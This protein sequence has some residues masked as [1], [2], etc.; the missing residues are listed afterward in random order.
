MK[1]LILLLLL[2]TACAPAFPSKFVTAWADL[3]NSKNL[4]V[5]TGVF[6]DTPDG[7][8]LKLNVT[9]LPPGVHALHIHEV[10]KCEPPDFKSA[11]AHYNPYGKKHGVKNFEGPHA[12]DLPNIIVGDNGYVQVEILIKDNGFLANPNGTSLVIHETADDEI[13]D[14]AGNSGSRIACG[15]IKRLIMA[16]Y[17]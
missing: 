3:N 7:I 13:T 6:V 8:L 16:R 1:L 17:G 14:P 10:G 5:G 2:I 15:V 11:G 4:P 9:A 12:G